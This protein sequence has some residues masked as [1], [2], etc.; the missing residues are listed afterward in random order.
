MFEATFTLTSLFRK[1]CR[2]AYH[3]VFHC[4]KVMITTKTLDRLGMRLVP[5]ISSH[6]ADFS[7]LFL[8]H[9]QYLDLTANVFNLSNMNGLRTALWNVENTTSIVAIDSGIMA[10]VRSSPARGRPRSCYVTICYLPDAPSDVALVPTTWDVPIST[11]RPIQIAICVEL[12]L[13]VVLC[14]RR[15]DRYV[16]DLYSE[17]PTG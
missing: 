3:V 7:K 11:C 13:L 16:F 9:A 17:L 1:T 8:D 6:T 14:H 4:A 5:T 15:L 10:Q 12:D 2:E